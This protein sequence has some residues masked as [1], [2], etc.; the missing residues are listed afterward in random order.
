MKT[1]KKYKLSNN[2]LE[3]IRGLAKF[4]MNECR[5]NNTWPLDPNGKRITTVEEMEASLIESFENSEFLNN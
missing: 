1:K 4:A 2:D 5:S 3:K